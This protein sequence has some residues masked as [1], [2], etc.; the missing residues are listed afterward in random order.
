MSESPSLPKGIQFAKKTR[1]AR[2]FPRTIKLAMW[3]MANSK[4]HGTQTWIK[5]NNQ[6]RIAAYYG[7]AEAYRN[8]PDWQHTDLRHNNAKPVILSHGYDETKPMGEFTIEDMQQAAAFRGGKCLSKT[9][10]KGDWDTQLE[11]QCAEGH[12]FK[13]SPRLILL[14]GHWCPEDLPDPYADISDPRP[15]RYDEIA[16]HN[17]FLAQL[18][19]PL[20]D[21]KENNTYDYHIFDGWE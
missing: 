17:P 1:I 5:R 11:W 20:H 14:G 8:I 18:W 15:W 3:K 2:C 19:Q 9:M 21:E 16:R 12:T 6:L 4:E 10:T 13:A 7:S